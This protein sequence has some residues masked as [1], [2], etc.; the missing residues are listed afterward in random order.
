MTAVP[1]PG[2]CQAFSSLPWC[3]Q[4]SA[5]P[6]W[7]LPVSVFALSSFIHSA[8]SCWTC[9]CQLKRRHWPGLPG[10]CVVLICCLPLRC[11]FLKPHPYPCSPGLFSS[12]L[13]SAVWPLKTSSFTPAISGCSSDSVPQS[14]ILYQATNP[15]CLLALGLPGQGDECKVHWTESAEQVWAQ[16]RPLTSG[17][18]NSVP[19]QSWR[20][21][22][23][24]WNS[25]SESQVL[26]SSKPISCEKV[27]SEFPARRVWNHIHH[28]APQTS[29]GPPSAGLSWEIQAAPCRSSLSIAVN[30]GL[31]TTR[32]VL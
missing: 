18:G 15:R 2:Q 3:A 17:L 19:S 26:S 6:A 10:F 30:I 21:H 5:S 7:R 12:S 16:S 22:S 4:H 29:L 25:V 24:G 23:E 31:M 32:P 8:D 28:P 13:P 27:V 1:L 20:P 11:A 14:W 9:M